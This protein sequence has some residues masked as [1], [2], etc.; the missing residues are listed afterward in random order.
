MYLYDYEAKGLNLNFVCNE[1]SW[2]N[3]K[4]I[5]PSKRVPKYV[6]L[7]FKFCVRGYFSPNLIWQNVKM[8]II[9]LLLWAL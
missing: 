7:E 3:W 8:V 2:P 9:P 4:G 1:F 5:A 6:E